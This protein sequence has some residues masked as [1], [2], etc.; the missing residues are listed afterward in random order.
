MIAQFIG[1]VK[2]FFQFFSK[3][4]QKIDLKDFTTKI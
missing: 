4:L 2:I 3:T 1:N